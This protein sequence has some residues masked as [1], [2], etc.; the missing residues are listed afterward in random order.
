[1][2]FGKVLGCFAFCFVVGPYGMVF[3]VL[4]AEPGL[5]MLTAVAF[6]LA[7]IGGAAQFTALS[8]M[9]GQGPTLII[10]IL[11]LTVNLRMALYSATLTQHLGA[12]TFG[13]EYWWLIQL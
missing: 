5:D 7:V 9:Q 8:L 13:P 1:M 10:I 4:A 12:A 11:S 6:S 3:G 2:T